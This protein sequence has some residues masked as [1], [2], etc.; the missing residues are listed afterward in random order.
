MRSQFTPHLVDL[1]FDAA[2]RSFWRKSAL[3]SFLQKSE[4]A[5]LPSWLPDE[6]K[7]DYLGRVFEHLRATDRG[8]AKILQLAIFLAEQAAFPDLH[9]WEDTAEKLDGAKRSVAALKSYLAEQEKAQA[10]EEQRREARTRMRES[11]DR[12]RQSQQ[13]LQSLSSRLT[14]LSG[15]LGTAEAGRAFEDW[16]YNL[17]QFSEI[18]ARRPYVSDG[19]QIDGSITLGDTTY[20]VECKFTS[21][22]CGATD[23]D[24]FR[25]KVEKVA[26]NTLGILVSI[27]GFSTTAVSEASGKKTPL[28]LLDH[29][30]IYRVLGGVSSFRD[31][32]ERVR[33]HCSQTGRAYLPSGQFDG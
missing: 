10:S 26:D 27:S 1:T 7:R 28:L 29:S 24:T 3:S 20:L 15:D 23:I 32:V 31:V 18:A 22:Q 25:A 19:R 14:E 2:L 17:M 21:E 33:R 9:G 5:G 6:S 16:F 12:A 11:Q 4:I 30:H 13:T 8:K